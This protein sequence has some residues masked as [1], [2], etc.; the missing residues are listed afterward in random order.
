MRLNEVQVPELWDDRGD[1]S[2]HLFPKA[3]LHGATFKV[4]SHILASSTTLSSFTRA[5]HNRTLAP[6][7]TGHKHMR[8]PSIDVPHIS[9]PSSLSAQAHGRSASADL[10]K[11]GDRSSGG[12]EAD[13]SEDTRIEYNV[14]LPL[15]VADP[16]GSA[17]ISDED[18]ENLI[19]IRNLFAFL[20]T[21]VL[22]A[23][24]AQSSI[25][26]II[27]NISKLLKHYDFTNL[28][29]SS[30]GEVPSSSFLHYVA[31]YRLGDVRG[32][33]EKT[34]EALV[35]GERMKCWPLYN[36][37]FVHAAGKWVELTQLNS[38][39]FPKLSETTRHRLERASAE[40]LSRVRVIETRLTEFEYPSLFSGVANSSVDYRSV[41]FKA[42]KASF[43]AMRKFVLNTYKARYG[44]WPPKASSKK[45][46]F[47]ESGLNRLVCLQVYQDMA[48]LYDLI[49]DR[50]DLTTRTA[51]FLHPEGASHPDAQ[52]MMM[53]IVHALRKMLGE[54]DRSDVPIQPPIPFDIPMLPTLSTTRRGFDSI[55]HDQ[56]VKERSKKLK[57]NEINQTLLQAVN[58]T[59]VRATLFV[60]AFLQHERSS[61]HGK[62]MAEIDDLRIGQWIFIYAVLQSLPLVAVDAPG[63]Q[64][65]QAVEH[66]LCEV[67]K[68]G[69]PW[70]KANDKKA[71]YGVAGG[72]GL[73]S[74]PADV[75]EHGVDG[76]FRR[77]HAWVKA[78]QWGTRSPLQQEPEPES[79][80]SIYSRASNPVGSLD[81]PGLTSYSGSAS[82][83]G[84]SI[85]QYQAYT[86][87][88]TSHLS[89]STFASNAAAVQ[90]NSN[91]SP[92]FPPSNVAELPSHFPSSETSL[93]PLPY[94]PSLSPDPELRPR[95][96]SPAGRNPNF[97]NPNSRINHT[98]TLPTTQRS[99]SPAPPSNPRRG[100]SDERVPSHSGS[101]RNI[102]GVLH[103]LEALPLPPGVV[104]AGR[105]ASPGAVRIEAKLDPNKSFDSIL[106]GIPQASKK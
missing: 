49:V 19:A 32:S 9:T 28:D 99:P 8:I 33:R 48:D 68:G 22:V 39:L 45:N 43:L 90:L 36:E 31:T 97:P 46:D 83:A 53:P 100:R 34:I 51:D 89:N 92:A 59:D 16:L 44:A 4:K 104:P 7:S 74:L 29:G 71:W 91:L 95:S 35:L 98:S 76:I 18:L 63:L 66:F 3:S 84:T 106:S 21:Q 69:A 1:T 81:S 52:S 85:S 75:V 102:G 5:G 72:A 41:N 103:G 60:E 88:F 78:E 42:W 40:L 64:Y 23:T 94:S 13:N 73:V 56:Q 101:A 37:A 26:S 6:H 67:P 54:F 30:F 70:T 86:P 12:F 47:S 24:P 65:T 80:T 58:K 38:P 20:T 96:I 2:V 87:Q 10:G 15:G 57:D 62:S 79:A 82:G 93:L 11:L 17:K 61:A 77:S 14:Y 55:S 25:F 105:T 50:N 27:W